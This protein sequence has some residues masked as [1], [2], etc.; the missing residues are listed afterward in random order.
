MFAFLRKDLEEMDEPQIREP[1]GQ[2]C[3]YAQGDFPLTME[4]KPQFAKQEEIISSQ[5]WRS[6]RMNPAE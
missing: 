2:S 1:E 3:E 4:N 6:R 5:G